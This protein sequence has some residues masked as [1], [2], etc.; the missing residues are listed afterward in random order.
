MFV[1]KAAGL[2]V[3]AKSA[4][5]Y[6]ASSGKILYQK[7][8]NEK[9]PIASTTKIMTG[10]LAIENANQEDIV[11]IKK[12]YTGI[13]GTSLYL[14][15]GEKISVKSLLYGLMLHSGNDAAV[16]LAGYVSGN[17]DNFVTAMNLKAK[18]IGMHNTSFKNPNGLPN[19][20]HYS[21]A[22]DM[23]KLAAY[24][25]KN[26]EFMKIV[27]A[28]NYAEDGRNF[29]NHNKLLKMSSRID[30][31]KTGFTKKAGR[32]LVSSAEENGMRLV[33]VTLSAPNDWNDHLKL[34]DFGFENYEKKTYFSKK[35]VVSNV[36][37]I[38]GCKKFLPAVAE[39]ELFAIASKGD[40]QELTVK[41][42]LPR[43]LYAPI[44]EK[45]IIGEIRLINKNNN[46][47]LSKVNIISGE[48]CEQMPKKS[49]LQRFLDSI[50]SCF[51]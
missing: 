13:E 50:S 49:F 11:E 26:A 16:A 4:I 48:S 36:S 32:C 25:T 14:K 38:G 27:S 19:E 29:V 8:A 31:I 20:E 5:L 30:G 23:A 46:E 10:L 42:Y 40:S 7:A 21:T 37:V 41:M 34:Y 1:S 28:K 43:F 17:I 12:E 39:E 22:Y 2:D 35:A 33:A 51:K 47:V 18:I 3:S 15:P 45:Q 6:E 44:I 9:M 24:S